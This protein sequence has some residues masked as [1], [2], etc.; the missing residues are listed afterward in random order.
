MNGAEPIIGA[1]GKMGFAA[2]LF[3]ASMVGRPGGVEELMVKKMHGRLAHEKGVVV[4]WGPFVGPRTTVIDAGPCGGCPLSHP[5][6]LNVRFAGFLEGGINLVFLHDVEE[7]LHPADITASQD[8]LR[9]HDVTDRLTAGCGT[10]DDFI[11]WSDF[12]APGVTA[13]GGHLFQHRAIGAEAI[14]TGGD[15]AEILGSIR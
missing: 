3:F 1:G 13:S 9:N 8:R 12:A 15:F 4:F 11:V 10:E 14:N 7:G 2:S 6:D 5:V